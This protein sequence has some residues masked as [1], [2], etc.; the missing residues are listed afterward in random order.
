[1]TQ[2][3]FI[4]TMLCLATLLPLAATAQLPFSLQPIPA[5]GSGPVENNEVP[6]PA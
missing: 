1:M 3:P 5:S 4:C 6:V 2:K